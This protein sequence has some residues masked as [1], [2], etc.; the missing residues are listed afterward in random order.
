MGMW[1]KGSWPERMSHECE[2]HMTDDSTHDE[3]AAGEPERR[4]TLWA[5]FGFCFGLA[6]ILFTGLATI[7]FQPGFLPLVS[8]LSIAAVVC[9]VMCLIRVIQS[10]GA[11]KGC[12][13]ATVGILMPGVGFCMGTVFMPQR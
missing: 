4:R 9:F 3:V 5:V 2:S 6:A 1:W 12:G 7:L 11:L 13:L 10:A 8:I